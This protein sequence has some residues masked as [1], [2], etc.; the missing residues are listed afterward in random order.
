MKKNFSKKKFVVW[1]KLSFLADL[2]FIKFK[3]INMAY[4][5]ASLYPSY[6]SPSDFYYQPEEPKLRL[7]VIFYDEKNDQMIGCDRVRSLVLKAFSHLGLLVDDI[8]IDE[9]ML[10]NQFSKRIMLTKTISV[11]VIEKK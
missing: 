9:I 10:M 6:F 2:K 5:F 1:P 3:I 8:Q 7:K 11:G 4:D